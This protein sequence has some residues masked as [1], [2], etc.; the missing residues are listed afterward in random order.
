[1]DLRFLE[2]LVAVV[3]R[4]SFAEAARMKG[5]TAA[6]VAQRIRKLEGI[7][8]TK[9]VMRSGH[10]VSATPACHALLPRARR[11]LR[12][13]EQLAGDLV[14]DG[15]GGTL[16]LGAISTSLADH[17][18][19]L[20]E[21]FAQA[22]PRATLTITPGTSI[23]LHAAVEAGTVDIAYLVEPPF[24]LPKTLR[25]DPSAEQSIVLVLPEGMRTDDPCALLT[26]HPLIAYDRASWGGR[27]VWDRV[28]RTGATPTVRCELDAVETIATLVAKGLGIAALPRWRGLLDLPNLQLLPLEGSTRRIGALS[29]KVSIRPELVDLCR[30]NP[31]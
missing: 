25:F 10:M 13:A 18:P 11:L 27:L 7:F 24:P 9:L 20:V 12:E 3:D 4:G 30:L 8:G 1:M 29:R 26:A 23:E 19:S 15:L 17:V 28:L 31:V 16:R 2:T 6:T 21:R 22:A 5:L 14:P